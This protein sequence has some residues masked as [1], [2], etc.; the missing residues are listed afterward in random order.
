MKVYWL[1]E[2]L[3]LVPESS[4][5]RGRIEAIET[6]LR[7]LEG[8]SIHKAETDQPS[9]TSPELDCSRVHQ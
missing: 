9:F 5:D 6:M 4:V 7:D 3:R 2:G 1:D 8:V